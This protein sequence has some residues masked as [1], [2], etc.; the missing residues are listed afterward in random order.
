MEQSQSAGYSTPHKE[1][2]A[3]QEAPAPNDAGE[4][5]DDNMEVVML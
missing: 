2:E 1:P 5:D 3:V 4:V